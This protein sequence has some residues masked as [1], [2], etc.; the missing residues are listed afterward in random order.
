MRVEMKN[1]S[2]GYDINRTRPTNGYEYTK[3]KI[4]KFSLAFISH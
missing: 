2:H 3:C 1:R 4:V